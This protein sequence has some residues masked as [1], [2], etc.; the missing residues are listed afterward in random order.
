MKNT[1][2]KSFYGEKLENAIDCF[3]KKIKELEMK[4]KIFLDKNQIDFES[5][6]IFKYDHKSVSC[7][8]IDEKISNKMGDEIN[9][10]FN[11]CFA[12]IDESKS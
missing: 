10:V 9:R 2:I 3:D 11:Y 6:Y 5:S 4:Y 8:I 1:I 7:I 12:S